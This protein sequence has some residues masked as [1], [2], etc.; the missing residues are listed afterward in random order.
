[1]SS[2]VKAAFRVCERM[3]REHYENFPVASLLIP[4]DRRPYVAAIYAFART[5]DDIA[6]EGGRSP[7][8]RLR[9]LEQVDVRLDSAYRGS[10]EVA[11]FIAIAETASRTGIPLALLRRLLAAFRMDV[12][13]HRY[14][15][16]DDLLGY[17]RNSADPVGRL[18]LHIF[19]EFREELLVQSDSLCTALQLVNFWQDVVPDLAR[20][21]LYIPLEDLGRFGYTE[22]DLAARRLDDR[23]RALM[24]FEV[25]RTRAMFRRGRDLLRAA[26]R[27]L[28]LELNLTYRGG[29]AI[30]KKIE[31]SGYD[32]LTDRPTLSTWDKI[33]LLASA[34]LRRTP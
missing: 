31:T 23:F 2:S 20:G 22:A 21:R 6:D 17:C 11:V 3:A 1:M 14:Q 30:L 16:F 18:V 32:V 12:T 15:S 8:E 26:V 9:L 24:R 13:R 5:A 4:R 7:Q 19:G 33:V 10:P 28:R 25:E 34:G 29:M 27:P